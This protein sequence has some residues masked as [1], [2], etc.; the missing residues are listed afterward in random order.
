MGRRTIIAP[1]RSHTSV[2]CA[3]VHLDGAVG[4]SCGALR[5]P[6]DRVSGCRR[7]IARTCGQD[8]HNVRFSTPEGSPLRL[9]NDGE[10]TVVHGGQTRR[11]PT[12]RLAGEGAMIRQVSWT[13]DGEEQHRE[14]HV[15]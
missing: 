1:A 14:L 4:S 13:E 11:L 12:I 15:G 6:G 5:V 7:G 8:A 3:V 2:A 10:P 9:A